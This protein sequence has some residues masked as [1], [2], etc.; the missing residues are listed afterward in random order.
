MWYWLQEAKYGDEEDQ[1]GVLRLIQNGTFTDQFPLHDVCVCVGV[2]V[3]G[4]GCGCVGVS[5]GGCGYVGGGLLLGGSTTKLMFCLDKSCFL[6]LSLVSLAVDQCNT[7][8]LHFVHSYMYTTHK[9]CLLP[10]RSEYLVY[11]Y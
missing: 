3:C 2:C 5:V 6:Y 1:V 9:T 4:C 10:S 11:M 8:C 7:L